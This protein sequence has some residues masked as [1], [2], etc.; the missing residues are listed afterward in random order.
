MSLRQTSQQQIKTNNVYQV[1][2]LLRKLPM[3]RIDLSRETGLSATSMTRLTALLNGWGYLRES[4]IA[5]TGMVGRKATLLHLRPE[6]AYTLGIHLDIRAVRI[7]LLDLCY[8]IVGAT[9]FA[10]HPA[11]LTPP[12]LA[13]LC[14][15]HAQSLVDRHGVRPCDTVYG[16]IAAAGVVSHE[17]QT[18]V[19]SPQLDWKNIALASLFSDVFSIPFAI[20][21]DVKASLTGEVHCGNYQN[22]ENIAFLQA[23]SGV[24]SAATNQG[25]IIRGE[26]NMAGEVGHLVLDPSND[27]LCDCG[28]R[29]CLQTHI[30]ERF[31]L[32]QAKTHDASIADMAGL[33]RQFTL[34]APWAKVLIE[35]SFYQLL[36]ALKILVTMYN[37]SRIIVNGDFFRYFG[38]QLADVG[39]SLQHT[40]FTPFQQ[41]SVIQPAKAGE[42]SAVLGAAIIAQQRSVAHRISDSR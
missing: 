38:G 37:P 19:H 24:G 42:Q 28:R 14:Q 30:A 13:A 17:T 18:L 6:A 33:H 3:S 26:L 29:G 39:A 2:S 10:L 7:C 8:Q 31:L 32:A 21:N 9:S 16:A 36:T 40:L 34:G 1:L 5:P 35:N 25:R 12:Q 4:E 20:E 27:I 41:T 22:E 23:G 15:M 11:S